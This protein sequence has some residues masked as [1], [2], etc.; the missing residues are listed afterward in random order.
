MTT[1]R[2]SNKSARAWSGAGAMIAGQRMAADKPRPA[3]AAGKRRVHRRHD[4]FLRAAGVGDQRAGRAGG[5]G[6]NRPA[7]QSYRPACR[8]Q[9]AAPPTRPSARFVTP[10]SI[11]PTCAAAS[12]LVCR[13][14]TPTIVARQPP[15]AQRQVRSSHR[16]TRRRQWPPYRT[17]PCRNSKRPSA[18]RRGGTKWSRRQPTSASCTSIRMIACHFASRYFLRRAPTLQ[19]PASSRDTAPPTPP[20]ESHDCSCRRHTACRRPPKFRPAR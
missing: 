14:P 18:E 5:R 9:R 16:S 3:A 12:R 2:P 6:L 1:V 11:A 19:S 15:F 17:Q 8:R 20:R 13:R 4:R 10:W 7:R